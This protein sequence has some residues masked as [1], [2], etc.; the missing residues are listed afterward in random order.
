MSFCLEITGWK[1]RPFAIWEEYPVKF[2][3]R[4]L[5]ALFIMILVPMIMTPVYL[6][7]SA[8]PGVAYIQRKDGVNI[9]VHSE[10]DNRGPM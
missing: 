4:M 7:V 8:E 6:A 3:Q 10:K 9:F 1:N 2:K 5:A